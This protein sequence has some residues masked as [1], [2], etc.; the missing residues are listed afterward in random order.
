VG[1][2]AGSECDRGRR[3]TVHATAAEFAEVGAQPVGASRDDVA[4][5]A[6]FASKHDL[7][8]PLLADVDGSV[9][10]IFGAKRLGP[11]WSRRQTFVID[12]DRRLLG[13]IRSETDMTSHA[14]EALALLRERDPHQPRP[15]QRT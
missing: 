6:W 11:L 8:Y 7:T 9:A 12:G 5:Q 13:H 2:H 14:D 15:P 10:A 4:T 3:P 1:G